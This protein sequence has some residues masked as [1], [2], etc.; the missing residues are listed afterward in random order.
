MH[1]EKLL[2]LDEEKKS[3]VESLVNSCLREDGLSRELYLEDD[4]N[5][6]ENFNSFFLLYEQQQLV[7]VLTIF[8]MSGREVEIS[9]YTLPSKRRKGL[10]TLLLDAAEE[11][12]LDLDI[13]NIQLVIEPSSTSGKL[14][15]IALGASYLY[16]EYLL[17]LKL[18][19]YE[20]KPIPLLTDFDFKVS[21]LLAKDIIQAAYIHAEIFNTDLEV[22]EEL[23]QNVWNS[24]CMVCY[25]AKLKDKLIGIC[26]V[27]YSKEN[28]S[29]FGYGILPV[30]QGNGYGIGLFDYVLRQ[31]IIEKKNEVN[32]Q[33]NSK[34]KKAIKIYNTIGFQVVTQYDYYGYEIEEEE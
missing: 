23:I 8:L 2:Q 14:A 3:E 7:S 32:L 27:N 31:L 30:Y 13:N 12:L 5:F 15:A 34:S 11:E 6:Y 20:K 18:E 9:G 29:I 16:S 33:V 1:I 25:G 21:R 4:I 10:F 22:S 19:E 28:A 24:N 17:N 26:N